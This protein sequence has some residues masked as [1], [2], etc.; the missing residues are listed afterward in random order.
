VPAHPDDEVIGMG[1]HLRTLPDPWI[2]YV[3]DGAPREPKFAGIAGFRTPSEYAAARRQEALAALSLAEVPQNHVRYIGIKDQEASYHLP[4]LSD[5]LSSTFQELRTAI[6]FTHPYEGGH[7]DH[8]AA[9]F[10]VRVACRL[11]ARKGLPSPMIAEFTSYHSAGDGIAVSEF[12]RIH[13]DRVV[14][15]YLSSGQR[16]LK[17]RMFQAYRTQEKILKQFPIELERF[18]PAPCYDFTQP[19]QAGTLYYE[20][21]DWG[22]D[23]EH[24]RSLAAECL[25]R[26][27]LSRT[28]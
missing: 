18:R 23:G 6:V 7:P 10:A 5:A 9:A 3:T 12:V 21:F 2:C 17:S 13:G 11:L 15:M 25:N 1:G 27:G 28:A 24:W 4:E 20:N 22:I 26:L 19:P 8:D 14:T 16:S